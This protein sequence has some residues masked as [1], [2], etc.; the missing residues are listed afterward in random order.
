MF[1]LPIHTQTLITKAKTSGA[2]F[3]IHVSKIAIVE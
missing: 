1:K 3:D 2:P